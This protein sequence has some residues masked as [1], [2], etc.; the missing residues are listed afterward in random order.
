MGRFIFKISVKGKPYYGE[1]STIVDAPISNLMELETF[2]DYYRLNYGLVGFRELDERL[3]RV[4]ETGCSG[5]D[6]TLKDLLSWNRAGKN[7][8]PIRTELGLYRKYKLT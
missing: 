2:K 7:E 8:G 6:H 5:F 4:E 1:W 3:S